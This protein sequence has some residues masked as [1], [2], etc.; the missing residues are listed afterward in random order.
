MS[1]Q[2]SRGRFVVRAARTVP[3]AVAVDSV[4]LVKEAVRVSNG[5]P[6]NRLEKNVSYEGRV[7]SVFDELP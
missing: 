4:A 2:V 1:C 3:G 6:A 7:A 5:Y